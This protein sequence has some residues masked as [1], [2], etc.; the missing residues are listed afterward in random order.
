MARGTE[1]GKGPLKI[2]LIFI[3]L[4]NDEGEDSRQ[5]KNACIYIKA[6]RNKHNKYVKQN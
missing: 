5:N 1:R 4:K 3:M 2:I 6:Q